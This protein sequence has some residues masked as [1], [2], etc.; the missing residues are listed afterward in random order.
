MKAECCLVLRQELIN[1]YRDSFFSL[2]LVLKDGTRLSFEDVIKS[3]DSDTVSYACGLGRGLSEGIEIMIRVAKDKYPQ[4][5][6][7]LRDLLFNSEFDVER[8]RITSKKAIQGLPSQKRSG[9]TVAASAY[10]S[11]ETDESKSISTTAQLLYRVEHEPKVAERLQS[12]PEAVVNDL[13]ALRTACKTA[14]PLLWTSAN[15]RWQ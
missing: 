2:P 15:Y 5:I 9:N 7:W 12:E 4:A 11:L 10:N 14:S 13:K 1:L 3:L 8:L 6:S